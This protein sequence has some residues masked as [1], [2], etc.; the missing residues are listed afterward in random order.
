MCENRC[1]SP[2]KVQINLEIS[3]F[4]QCC[5]LSRTHSLSHAHYKLASEKSAILTFIIQGTIFSV[6]C[7]P[8]WSIRLCQL[9]LG[10][11]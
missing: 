5:F 10:W 9:A 1:N 11:N 6:K 7:G 8:A 3:T 2:D 4:S